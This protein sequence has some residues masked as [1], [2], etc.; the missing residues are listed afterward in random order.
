VQLT[1]E[2]KQV[3]EKLVAALDAFNWDK[4]KDA[5]CDMVGIRFQT[6]KSLAAGTDLLMQLAA[7][8]SEL[9]VKIQNALIMV[10]DRLTG[11]CVV[12]EWES[13]AENLRGAKT[14]PVEAAESLLQAIKS[15]KA[16]KSLFIPPSNHPVKFYRSWKKVNGVCQM[17]TRFA[18]HGLIGGPR[19]C[20][21]DARLL[22]RFGP[23]LR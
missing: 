7:H 12:R 4:M 6:P 17:L 16:A 22:R 1:H 14:N 8:D 5:E 21:P 15:I 18:F 20:G 19:G 9:A 2:V 10:V 3:A 13:V 11:L 23:S